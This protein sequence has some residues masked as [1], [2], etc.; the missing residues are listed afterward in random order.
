MASYYEA[1]VDM[2]ETSSEFLHQI[3]LVHVSSCIRHF[4]GLSPA[5]KALWSD[6]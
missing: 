5:T 6:T 4:G 2:G 3:E 1:M